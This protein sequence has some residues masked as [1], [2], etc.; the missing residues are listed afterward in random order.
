MAVNEQL[1]SLLK[2]FVSSTKC[3]LANISTDSANFFYSNSFLVILWRIYCCFPR[4]ISGFY[5]LSKLD[6]KKFPSDNEVVGVPS[7]HTIRLTFVKLILLKYETREPSPAWRKKNT[8]LYRFAR[9]PSPVY[10]IEREVLCSRRRVGKPH[11]RT[12]EKRG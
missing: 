6:W 4:A 5:L 12:V 2:V 3:L 1:L 8:T 11:V 10:Y 9:A 7:C